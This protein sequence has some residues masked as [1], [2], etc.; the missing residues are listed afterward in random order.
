MFS[1]LSSQLFISGQF[2]QMC[3]SDTYVFLQH[4]SDLVLISK[5][6]AR[7]GRMA[8]FYFPVKNARNERPLSPY[9]SVPFPRT[10]R[11]PKETYIFMT[12]PLGPPFQILET[13]NPRWFSE[14]IPL[15]GAATV[16]RRFYLSLC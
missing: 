4:T 11:S 3:R 5:P 7:S 1:Q 15:A 10:I 14:A 16:N 8:P 6:C 2:C 12:V 13:H 9:P